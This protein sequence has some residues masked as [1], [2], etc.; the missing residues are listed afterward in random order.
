MLNLQLNGS[1]GLNGNNAPN[2][3]KAV[4]NALNKLLGQIPPT[5]RLAVDGKLGLRPENSNTVQAIKTFQKKIVGLIR[6]DGRID[7]NGKTHQIL[8]NKLRAAVTASVVPMSASEKAIL[9]SK[10]EQY[11]DNIEHMYL[12]T[13]GFVTVGVGHLIANAEEAKKLKFVHR[14]S[15]VAATAAEIEA[16]FESIKKLSSKNKIASFFKKHTSL[17][18]KENDIDEMT[19]K[20]ISTF[21]SELKRIYGATEFSN[22][23]SKVKL[24]LFDMIFNLGMTPLKNGFP[25]F[26]RHIK[27]ND[28]KLAAT[29]CNRPDVSIERNNY[30]RGLLNDAANAR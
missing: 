20:H 5:R 19:N 6:P 15:K 23:P 1:V 27:A 30:V 17:I 22:F 28:W 7:K 16:E 9:R 4:Q 21:E 26:N 12:D 10:L 25:N 18:L 29:E 24:A 2:D 3:I 14:S 13:K 11:E 8:N